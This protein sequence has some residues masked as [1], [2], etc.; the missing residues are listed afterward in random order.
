[1][2]R[3]IKR[4]WFKVLLGVAATFAVGGLALLRYGFTHSG[5]K[6][7]VEPFRIA[8]NLYYVGAADVTAFLLTGREGHVV[9]D[10]G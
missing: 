3:L 6:V 9:I 10:G 1:M 8:G 7:P 4:R 5:S 2:S